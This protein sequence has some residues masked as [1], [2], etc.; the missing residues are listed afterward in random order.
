MYRQQ[1]LAA[2]KSIAT[3]TIADGKWTYRFII[4]YNYIFFNS[5]Q[6]YNFFPYFQIC[7]LCILETHQV[8]VFV[9]TIWLYA[10]VKRENV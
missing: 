9:L 8:S 2:V 5:L 6:I 4:F 7:Y 10:V 3:S 1:L